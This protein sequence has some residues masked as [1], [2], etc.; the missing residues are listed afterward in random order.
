MNS[1]KVILST[2][3]FGPVQYFLRF[4]DY[5]EV[6]I[7]QYDN[8]S[9]QTYR[10]RCIFGGSNGTVTLTVPVKKNTAKKTLV[11]DIRIDYDTNWQ[12]N[13]FRTLISC[14][15]S[16]PFF[17]YMSDDIEFYFRKKFKFLIDL[18]TDLTIRILDLLGLE[19]KLSLTLNYVFTN[20]DI[21]LKDLRDIISP[22]KNYLED[23][24]F[25][26]VEYHQVFTEKNGFLPNL[27][28][29]D[30]LFNMGGEAANILRKSRKTIH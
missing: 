11:R 10:N 29:L 26:P 14:Y 13:H 23:T 4:A 25:Q 21:E 18:N 17:E 19:T 3:Y 22:K 15:N 6:L 27:S 20:S 7:E 1:D 12:K 8:Y 2:A 9:R 24:A 16:S 28:I 30:L 5:N